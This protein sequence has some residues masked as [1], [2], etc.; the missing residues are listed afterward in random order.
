MT[1]GR[2]KI[3]PADTLYSQWLRRERPC[4]ERCGSVKSNQCSHFYGRANE[5]TRFLPEN[6]DVLCAGC[7]QYF[8]ANPAEYV[9]WKRERMGDQE[10]KKL[11][12]AAD[13]YKKKDDVLILMWLAQQG[14]KTKP[15]EKQNKQCVHK[16]KQCVLCHLRPKKKEK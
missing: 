15:K 1:F 8:T 4:C 7:H 5:A 10:F 9:R 6:T 12:V 11:E 13:T 14:M 2:I 16:L 3:R